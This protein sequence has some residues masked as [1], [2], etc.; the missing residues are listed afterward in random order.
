MA[1]KGSCRF[2]EQCGSIVSPGKKVEEDGM[3]RMPEL[4]KGVL[5]LNSDDRV[6][7]AGRKGVVPVPACDAEIWLR[8]MPLSR[9]GI[10]TPS[11]SMRSSLEALQPLN[12]SGVAQ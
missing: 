9:A 3:L 8:Y 12:E 7:I 5:A 10:E 11:L 4:S 6:R 2:G 1:G